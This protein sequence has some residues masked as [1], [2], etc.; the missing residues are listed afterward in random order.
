MGQLFPGNAFALSY[1]LRIKVEFGYEEDVSA[2][3]FSGFVRVWDGMWHKRL[4]IDAT[5]VRLNMFVVWALGHKYQPF[6]VC[7]AQR[8]SDNI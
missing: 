3:N 1:R 7:Q 5:Q 2:C 8:L 6:V 4:E